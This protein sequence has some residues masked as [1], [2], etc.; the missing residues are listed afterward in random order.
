MPK[1]VVGL[2]YGA[3]CY[4]IFFGTFLYAIGFVGGGNLYGPDK[5]LVTPNSIDLSNRGGTE[6]LTWRIIID[7]LLLGL[8]AIQH[9]VMARQW[10]K[11]RWTQVV[12]PLLERSTY[13]LI[14]SLT[15]L[16]MFWQWRPIGTSAERVLWDVHNSTGRLVLESL[17]WIGWLIVLTSTFLIDHFELFGLKQSYSYMQG[18]ALP[19]TDFKVTAFYKGVRH[20]LYL[21]FMIAFWSTP[22]M[23]LGHLFFA[24]MTTAYMLLAIQFEERDLLRAHGEKYAN[25]RRQVS[26]LT[27]VRL[28]KGESAASDSKDKAAGA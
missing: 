14:A 4:L 17:F 25:Y 3:L 5:P 24:V 6:S 11:R 12:A 26:M 27:P 16:L 8:F 1:R 23:S 19:Q 10:F 20:P 15:L 9:S 7:A 13:V 22:R 18:K 2:A 28:W 21:G